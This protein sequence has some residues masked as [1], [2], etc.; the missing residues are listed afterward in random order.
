MRALSQA[1]ATSSETD[2]PDAAI[3]VFTDSTSNFEF[4]GLTGSCQIKSSAGTSGPMYRTLGP[5]SRCVNL[6]QALAN[7]S[8]K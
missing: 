1:V 5:I 6:N 4:P 7:T 3:L 8:S 2:K